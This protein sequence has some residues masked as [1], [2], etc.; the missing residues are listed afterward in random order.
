MEIKTKEQAFLIANQIRHKSIKEVISQ[1][2]LTNEFNLKNK[3]H[4]G[5]VIEQ[6]FGVQKNNINA[7]DLKYPR[8]WN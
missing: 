7:P 2:K 5:H 8:N 3:G 1:L 6:C 4:V